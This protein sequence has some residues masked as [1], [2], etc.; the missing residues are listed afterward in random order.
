MANS[1]P[2]N[3]ATTRGTE[4][5]KSPLNSR[6]PAPAKPSDASPITSQRG[7]QR[8]PPNATTKLNR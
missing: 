1:A 8:S 4:L 6:Y 2:Q 3:M 7:R 5:Y